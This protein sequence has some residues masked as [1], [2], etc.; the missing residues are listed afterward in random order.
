M[1][2]ASVEVTRAS[3]CGLRLERGGRAS[4]FVAG[5]ERLLRD[6]RI[7]IGRCGWVLRRAGRML[8]V[9]GVR[10]RSGSSGRPIGAGLLLQRV[11]RD[12]PTMWPF[13]ARFYVG[14]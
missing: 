11:T 5:G 8:V 6:A 12:S 13:I 3:N 2:R 14:S 1:V 4:N 10:C 7:L 9:S